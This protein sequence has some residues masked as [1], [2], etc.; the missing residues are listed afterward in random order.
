GGRAGPRGPRR[1]R[2]LLSHPAPV[3]SARL[4]TICAT[5]RKRRMRRF[6]LTAVLAVLLSALAGTATA[7]AKGGTDDGF[8]PSVKRFNLNGYVLQTSYTLGR[9]KGNTFKQTYK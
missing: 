8:P 5:R 3:L 6:V 7:A 2:D 1:D 4:S 9:N